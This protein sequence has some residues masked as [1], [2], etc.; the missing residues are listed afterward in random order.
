MP[1]I[2]LYNRGQRTIIGVH[3]G[4]Y[5]E[6]A[7]KVDPITKK[8]VF[9]EKKFAF[10]PDTSQA[11]NEPTARLLRR[12]LPNEI[13]SIEDVV[14]EYDSG[15]PKDGT[16]PITISLQEADRLRDAAIAEAVERALITERQR[17]ALLPKDEEKLPEK[18]GDEATDQQLA[19]VSGMKKQIGGK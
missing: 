17:V 18:T 6:K 4:E 15:K 5:E 2:K 13:V 3:I 9:L 16:P 12:L 14:K 19:I 7:S 11:F 1:D 8:E 10:K